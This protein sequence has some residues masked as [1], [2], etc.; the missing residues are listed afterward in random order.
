MPPDFQMKR[1]PSLYSE[2]FLIK[3]EFKREDGYR[4]FIREQIPAIR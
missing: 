1:N 4:L 2:G 3:S